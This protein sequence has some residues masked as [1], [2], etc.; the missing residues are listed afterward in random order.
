MTSHIR[1]IFPDEIIEVEYTGYG[2][3]YEDTNALMFFDVAIPSLKLAFEYQGE[4]HYEPFEHL[5]GEEGLLKR[6]AYDKQKRQACVDNEVILIEIPNTW[7]RKAD[8]IMDILESMDIQFNRKYVQQKL[9]E[10][11]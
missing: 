5:G 3:R 1:D 11:E 10:F 7:D 6:I 8:Y 4:Q 9:S 2:F